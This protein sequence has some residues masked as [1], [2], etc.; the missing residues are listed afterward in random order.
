MAY[1]V[2]YDDLTSVAFQVAHHGPVRQG[3]EGESCL[4]LDGQLRRRCEQR[5]SRNASTQLPRSL[6]L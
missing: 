5:L 3:R 2:H 1:R 4:R 6:T